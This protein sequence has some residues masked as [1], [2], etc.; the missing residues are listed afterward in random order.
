MTDLAY[1]M[2]LVK[3]AIRQVEQVRELTQ[4]IEAHVRG[5]P[6]AAEEFIRPLSLLLQQLLEGQAAVEALLAR[7]FAASRVALA[8]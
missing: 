7:L 3:R 5:D 2:E 8:R 1:D 6:Q 4:D